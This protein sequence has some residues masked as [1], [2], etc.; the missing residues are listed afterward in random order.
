MTVEKC[1]QAD[2]SL[3]SKLKILIEQSAK[4]DGFITDVEPYTSMNVYKEMPCLFTLEDG[5][6][7]QAALFVFAPGSEEIEINALVHP[8]SRNKGYFR[9]L[10]GESVRTC[11]EFGY[12]KGLFVCAR[13][14]ESGKKVINHW[15]CALDHAELQMSCEPP[16]DLKN[17]FHDVEIVTARE[18]DIEE[19]ACL[20]AAA[21]GTDTGF[22]KGLI[23]N[24]LSS[25]NRTQYIAKNKGSMVGLCSASEDKGKINIFGL[26]VYPDERRKGYARSLLDRISMDAGGKEIHELCLDVDEDNPGAIALYKSF[27]FKETDCTEYYKFTFDTFRQ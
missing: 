27:G 11:S 23:K 17:S 13:S 25:E 16:V 10:L 18:S 15:V 5:G 2:E 1:L 7:L 3:L 8:V 19:L 26:G 21:F 20:G 4:V 12:D 6:E 9:L 14:S 22:E 24:T